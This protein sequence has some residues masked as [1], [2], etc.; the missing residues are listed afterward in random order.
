ML[1]LF[2]RLARGDVTFKL[3][4]LCLEF[5]LGSDFRF[6]VYLQCK[7]VQFISEFIRVNFAV[8]WTD[9]TKTAQQNLDSVCLARPAYAFLANMSGSN[10]QSIKPSQAS[11]T[12]FTPY[13]FVVRIS[14]SINSLQKVLCPCT[15][16]VRD[17]LVQFNVH[18]SELIL[19]LPQEPLFVLI[20]SRGRNWRYRFQK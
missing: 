13:H 12:H 10:E 11:T 14:P 8:E 6:S 2:E 17:A 19:Q 20:I 18:A 15:S 7:A 3:P 16:Y 9:P 4:H 5:L 1:F